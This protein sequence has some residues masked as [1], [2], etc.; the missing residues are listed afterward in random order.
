LQISQN[1]KEDKGAQEG[2]DDH[3]LTT[4][5]EKPVEDDNSENDKIKV[6]KVTSG[7]TITSL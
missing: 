5:Q 7:Q 6:E 3:P 1:G 4:A 2:D